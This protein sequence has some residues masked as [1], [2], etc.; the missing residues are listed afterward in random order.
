MGFSITLKPKDGWAAERKR[1]RR[2]IAIAAV[3]LVIE[4]LAYHTG[5]LHEG[6]GRYYQRAPLNALP[7]QTKWIQT[8]ATPFLDAGR[9]DFGDVSM[10]R[11]LLAWQ[12]AG[13]SSS[14]AHRVLDIVSTM[15]PIVMGVND[16]DLERTLR[17]DQASRIQ[18]LHQ[19]FP[20]LYSKLR[21]AHPLNKDILPPYELNEGWSTVEQRL[22]QMKSHAPGHQINEKED[23]I[24]AQSNLARAVGE[25]GIR[26]LRLGFIDEQTALIGGMA[27]AIGYQNEQMKTLTGWSG[28]VLGLEGRVAINLQTPDT[29]QNAGITTDDPQDYIQVVGDWWTLPHEWFHALD[30]VAARQAFEYGGRGTL[31]S[32]LRLFRKVRDPEL[33]QSWQNAMNSIVDA[34]AHWKRRRWEQVIIDLDPYLLSPSEAMAFAFGEFAQQGRDGRRHY[35]QHLM[36]SQGWVPN[37][38]ETRRQAVHWQ[39]LF[40]EIKP[41]IMLDDKQ[42]HN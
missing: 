3:L 36:A 18:R 42:S 21:I 4:L 26:V 5:L 17:E 33:V 40:V 41:L 29:A 19:E 9:D 16:P 39:A 25:G 15:G 31:T 8:P 28:R 13:M 38:I 27:E 2:L 12:K 23:R 6:M 7:M 14:Q 37:S 11:L 10:H 20:A 32:N 35:Q 1:I 34:E 22:I 30:I 24:L